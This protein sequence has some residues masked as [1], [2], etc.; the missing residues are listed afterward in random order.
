MSGELKKLK[1]RTLKKTWK[2]DLCL[3]LMSSLIQKFIPRKSMH[4]GLSGNREGIL[5]LVMFSRS[6]FHG[7]IMELPFRLNTNRNISA[8]GL[9]M[10]V[11][12]IQINSDMLGLKT[13]RHLMHGSL[14]GL[15]EGK[16]TV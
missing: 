13:V 9:L 15:R 1:P 7:S 14:I 6:L 2:E 10:L 4:S 3:C 11:I 5:F 16:L 8:H 12:L